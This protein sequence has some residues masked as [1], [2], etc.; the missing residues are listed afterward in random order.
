M[1]G[2]GVMLAFQI[3]VARCAPGT[4]LRAFCRCTEDFGGPVFLGFCV[5]VA[6]G[7]VTRLEMLHQVGYVFSA[8]IETV[9]I[10]G[11]KGSLTVTDNEAV[12][13][14]ASVD[15]EE[16]AHAVFPL[17]FKTLAIDADQV[18]AGTAGVIGAYLKAGGE[19]QAVHFVFDA[20]DNDT[21]FGNGIDAL[22]PGIHQLDVIA[23]KSW[24]EAVVQAGAFAHKSVPGFEGLGGFLVFDNFIDA[25]ANVFHLLKVGHLEDF[26]HLF[27]G[28]VFTGFAHAA[29]VDL[30]HFYPGIVKLVQLIDL[31]TATTTTGENGGKVFLTFLLPAGFETGRP[32]HIGIVVVSRVNAGG[33]ALKHVQLLGRLAQVG[34]A[35]HRGS[36]GADNPDS[37]VFQTV[38]AAPGIAASVVIVPAAGVKCMT[39]ELANTGNAW[40]FGTIQGAVDHDDEARL[41]FVIAIGVDGP[42]PGVF[43]PDHFGDPGLQT[44]VVIQAIVLGDSTA[45]IENFRRVTELAWRH[46][47]EFFKQGQIGIGLDIAGR[48]GIAVP[49]PGA[50][51]IAAFFDHADVFDTGLTHAGAGQQATQTAANNGNFDF[52]LQRVTN[53]LLADIGVFEKVGKLSLH[54]LI[55]LVAIGAQAFGSLLGV[56]LS[57]KVGIEIFSNSL[58][59]H[60]GSSCKGLVYWVYPNY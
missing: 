10:V 11:G 42:A 24:Q 56:F 18:V 12:G 20:I 25:V 15:A 35:L 55:L 50:A 7:D 19:D 32:F 44:G 40:E 39:L 27:L 30:A 3:V 53:N 52:V 8:L 59:A 34:D 1:P 37:L 38:E 41:Y 58:A 33:R 31:A 46:V 48:A 60:V 54:F 28:H 13:K 47:A 17:V 51:E 9:R 36:A 26:Q 4:T 16:R 22:T 14:A 21:G 23:V 45:M 43:I 49:V 6:A 5:G 2:S 29:A 57:E